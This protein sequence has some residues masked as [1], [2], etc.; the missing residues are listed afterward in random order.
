MGSIPPS[1]MDIKIKSWKQT[2]GIRKIDKL[3]GLKDRY[4]KTSALHYVISMTLTLYH[5]IYQ[6][7]SVAK[8]ILCIGYTNG[9]KVSPVQLT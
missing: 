2:C 4:I 1:I 8:N 9:L 7:A 3:L 5:I 6:A